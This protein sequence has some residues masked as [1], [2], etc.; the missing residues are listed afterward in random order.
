MNHEKES[1]VRIGS[2]FFF[3][4]FGSDT[5]LVTSG[6]DPYLF[7]LCFKLFPTWLIQNPACKFSKKHAGPCGNLVFFFLG[8]YH[9]L[10]CSHFYEHDFHS[11][12]S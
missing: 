7:W 6:L 10:S 3:F 1:N 9:L 2:A 12:Q 4:F 8:L 11:N 5:S